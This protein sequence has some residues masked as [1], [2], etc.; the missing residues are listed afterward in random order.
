MI[1][2]RQKSIH[3]ERKTRAREGKKLIQV[4][5][6][7]TSLCFVCGFEGKTSQTFKAPSTGER[8]RES[9]SRRRIDQRW[10]GWWM[11]WRWVMHV[12]KKDFT[13][14]GSWAAPEPRWWRTGRQMMDEDVRLQICHEISSLYVWWYGVINPVHLFPILSFTGG[15]V[16][17]E[18]TATAVSLTIPKDWVSFLLLIRNLFFL[19]LSS[20][21]Q[22]LRLC[23]PRIF[24]WLLPQ[25]CLHKVGHDTGVFITALSSLANSV[26]RWVIATL[27]RNSTAWGC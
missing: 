4:S 13:P 20:W 5:E 23:W 6:R 7:T 9:H 15:S 22:L 12:Q 27:C 21:R 25:V 24:R 26:M 18:W 3:I 14:S 2:R 17:S 11:L 1:T 10:T 16:I 19:M 8:E